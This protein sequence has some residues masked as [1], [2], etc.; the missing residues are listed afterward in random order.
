[1]GGR[2]LRLAVALA[3]L[4]T[5]AP[6]RAGAGRV[7]GTVTVTGNDGS[8]AD[9]NG[10]IVYLVGFTEPAPE[11]VPSVVQKNKRF[12]PDLIA[13]TAGQTISFPNADPILHNVFSRSSVRPFDLGSYRRGDT[14]TKSFPTTGVVD[15]YCNIHPEMAATILVLPNRRFARVGADG[16]FT[17]D[18]VP[19]GTWTA[20]AY[21]RAAVRPARVE[22]TVAAGKD[23]SIHLD[24][25]R[26]AEAPHDNKYGEKYKEPGKYR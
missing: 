21:A 11:D 4:A 6:A 13:I 12:V 9:P 7:V 15:V 18:G 22:V 10:A 8:A 23:A 16:T 25:A 2:I 5:A 1:V 14:K 3:V 19:P 24:L 17:I 20:F 26:G